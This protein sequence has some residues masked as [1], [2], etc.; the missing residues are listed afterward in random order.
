M[1]HSSPAYT[2]WCTCVYQLDQCTPACWWPTGI[3][4]PPHCLPG[5]VR[6]GE[7]MQSLAAFQLHATRLCLYVEKQSRPLHAS[8]C[9]TLL[10][11]S[12]FTGN[13]E[14]SLFDLYAALVNN[15]CVMLAVKVAS[16]TCQLISKK[17]QKILHAFPAICQQTKVTFRSPHLNDIYIFRVNYCLGHWKTWILLR[18]KRC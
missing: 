8:K 10:S 6:T 15:E 7:P 1:L 17:K 12:K 3:W 4:C 13:F 18:T 11:F 2:L 5:Q 9:W 16:L 14:T